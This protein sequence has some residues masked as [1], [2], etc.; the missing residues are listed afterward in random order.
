MVELKLSEFCVYW[1][2]HPPR[3]SQGFWGVGGFILEVV[4]C[5]LLL[6]A[7]CSLLGLIDLRFQL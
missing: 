5:D 2:S 6:S 7:C 3:G 4:W 1:V